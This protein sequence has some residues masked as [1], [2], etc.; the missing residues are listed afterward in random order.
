[1]NENNNAIVADILFQYLKDT[2]YDSEN[3]YL[4][5]KELPDEFQK[6]GQGMQLLRQWIVEAKATSFALSKGDLSYTV[7]DKENVFVAPMKEL[8]GTLRHL[9]WQ[10]QQIAKGDY[11]QKVDFMGEFSHAFNLMT[12]QLQERRTALIEENQ[13]VEERNIELENA[14]HLSVA[15][16]NYTQNMIF[17]QSIDENLF[18]NEPAAQFLNTH[19][20][21]G[22][23]VLEK[24]HLKDMEKINTTQIWEFDTFS[25]QDE[26]QGH[27]YTV[28]SYPIYL[29]QKKTF[30]HIVLDETQ[31][32]KDEKHMYQMAYK[33][34][35][36]GVY[37]R[38]YALKQMQE[39]KENG[40]DFVLSFIDVDYLKY[41]NDTFGH[42]SGDEYLMEV[43]DYLQVVDG[44][45]CRCGGDE[46]MVIESGTTLQK[47]N[48]KLE[49]VRKKFQKYGKHSS[50]PQGFS[51]AS[52]MINTS[53]TKE[54]DEYFMI[55]DTLMYEYK[56]KNKQTLKDISYHDDR[57]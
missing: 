9:A 42:N 14:F 55:V 39:W 1:M 30:V 11:S 36:T 48:K 50:F 5:L 29:K 7:T 47:Q 24:L 49:E 43:V 13:I 34:P 33:D 51:Y 15:L 3:A 52:C 40:I 21:L 25:L 31:R 54:L 56:A 28:E 53:S 20:E 45:L 18:Q 2:I 41:C 4:D 22:K 23:Y 35:L 27:Y 46:F 10:T 32:K 19:Q 6:L 17:I 16:A 38:R 8:Q 37:N 44:L 12:Q 26:N 57:N